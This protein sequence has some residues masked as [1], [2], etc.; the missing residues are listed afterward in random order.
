MKRLLCIAAAAVF[1]CA[2]IPVSAAAGA[3]GAAIAVRDGVVRVLCSDGDS[4]YSGSAFV[5]SSD[6]DGTYVATNYHVV[7]DSDPSTVQVLDHKGDTTSA[8]IEFYSDSYDLCVLKTQGPLMGVATVSLYPQGDAAVGNEVYALGFPGA[9]DTL[10][11]DL[12]Y[13]VEDITV[14]NGIMIQNLRLTIVW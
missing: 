13:K 10:L 9:G 7:E 8:D 3:S 6:R 5:L 11:D 2:L 4:S 1:L 14:T 12:G